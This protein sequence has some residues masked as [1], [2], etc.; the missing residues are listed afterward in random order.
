[1]PRKPKFV[2]PREPH[3][4]VAE[5]EAITMVL[6]AQEGCTLPHLLAC[7]EAIL[8]ASEGRSTFGPHLTQVF[9][10]RRLTRTLL[11]YQ[12]RKAPPFPASPA[13]GC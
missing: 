7:C 2:I 12:T 8:E 10:I 1:M 4:E 6:R 3:E 9:R 13:S 11:G 5:Q